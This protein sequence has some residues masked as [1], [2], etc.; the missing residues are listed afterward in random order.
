MKSLLKYL[1]EYRKEAVLA[2]LF[3]LLEATFELIVP[4]VMAAIIDT[5]IG[6]QNRPYI[7]KMCGVLVLL[8]AVGLVSAITAQWF[9]AK[10]ATGFSAK[11]RHLLFEHIQELSFS[12]MDLFGTDTLITRMTSDV[13]Q[14]QN[15]VNLVLRLFMRSPFIVFGAMVMAF[16]VDVKA[17]LIFVVTIPVL[18]VVVFGIMLWTM[19][20]Y[21][22][23]QGKLDRIM[24]GTRENLT[25]V[26]VIRAFGREESE[27]ES[28][29][30]ENAALSRMQ[31]FVGK[32]SS[33]MNPVTYILINL[34]TVYLIYTGAVRV[35]CGIL[36]QGQV[37]AL[38]NYMS[39]ILVELIKLANLIIQV[40]KA[41]AC[42]DRIADIL[43]VEPD[44][45]DG[46][47]PADAVRDSET[48]V[49]FRNVSLTYE[50]GAGEALQNISFKVRRG[51]TIGIIGGTGSG[52]SSLV[53]LIPRFYDASQGEV[54]VGGH[55]VKEYRQ[56]ELRSRIG[57]VLQKA[58][59]F[60]GTIA[61]NLSFG[62]SNASAEEMDEALAV[63][64]AKEYVDLKPG[65]TEFELE[66]NGRNLSGGQKQ[67]MTIAR[68]LIRKPDILIL[69]DSAS[70]LDFAT[71]AKLRMAIRG[72]SRTLTTFIVS[73]RA[74][75]VQYADQILVMD[76]GRLA[77]IG[78]HAELLAGNPVYQEIYYSQFPKEEEA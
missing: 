74:A 17:A 45:K 61:R 75:S 38:L 37:V 64:Q 72:M 8:A 47:L 69:D 40:T 76:D 13:N 24:T 43:K 77:G 35:D 10:A 68:A 39:Q 65:R 15:G 57:V 62:K 2:P 6:T 53:N 14:V 34:A 67:R 26:R 48:T 12:Q 49:E 3:K 63:S 52:K 21:R 27:E 55:N 54:L 22:K 44:M 59:L 30:T 16:T 60:K 28:F 1:K 73:Q 5:G 78:T 25:G 51:E 23:V 9:A 70:A 33:L 20:L 46:L 18:S 36:T 32:I 31:Q 29:R 56:E 50:E 66:Q 11:L 42:G 71:D 7:L 58:V 19:P 4:L 41:W